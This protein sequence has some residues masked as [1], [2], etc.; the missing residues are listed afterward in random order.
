[1]PEQDQMVYYHGYQQALIGHHGMF[2]AEWQNVLGAMCT[3][4]IARFSSTPTQLEPFA[5]AKFDRDNRFFQITAGDDTKNHRH[6]AER[7]QATK[8]FRMCL[9]SSLLARENSAIL[10]VSNKFG[11]F[12]LVFDQ[13]SVYEMKYSDD[14]KI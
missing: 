8:S 10:E 6:R 7:D 5:K 13:C 14:L 3:E 1:V 11:Q 12:F 2:V 9:S 4:R